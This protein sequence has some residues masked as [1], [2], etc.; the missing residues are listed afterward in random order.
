MTKMISFY[1]GI[2]TL[3]VCKLHALAD[4]LQLMLTK[5]NGLYRLSSKES[6]LELKT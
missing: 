3:T 2:G 5:V 4:T 6:A 1:Q